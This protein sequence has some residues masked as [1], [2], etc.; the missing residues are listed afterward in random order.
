MTDSNYSESGWNV[1][2]Y[3]MTQGRGKYA[4]SWIYT[5]YN[6]DGEDLTS[7]IEYIMIY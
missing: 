5:K 3:N 6:V 7:E 4:F 1:Y 2:V